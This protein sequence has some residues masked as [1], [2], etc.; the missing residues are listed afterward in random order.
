MSKACLQNG[1]VERAIK[2]MRLLLK[3]SNHPIH[4]NIQ[5][6]MTLNL[7]GELDEAEELMDNCL[8]NNIINSSILR[9]LAQI[10]KQ[11]GNLKKAVILELRARD[12]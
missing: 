12:L 7:I 2:H 6:A 10:A 9:T 1:E 4:A 8:E 5:L 3:F 11:K